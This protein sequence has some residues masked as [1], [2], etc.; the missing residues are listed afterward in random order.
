MKVDVIENKKDVLEIEC[1]DK[2]LPNALLNVLLRN[3]VDAYTREL[4]PLK[5]QHRLHIEAVNPMEKLQNALKT[6]ESEWTE[7]GK[8]LRGELALKKS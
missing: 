2:I 5:P 7:F 4:H 8:K 6:V 3:K 1:D